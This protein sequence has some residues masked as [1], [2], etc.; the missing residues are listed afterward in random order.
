MHDM[1]VHYTNVR[2]WY[3]GPIPDTTIFVVSGGNK[4]YLKKKKKKRAMLEIIK[5]DCYL[6]AVKIEYVI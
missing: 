3:Q 5:R 6:R 2:W 1:T 4:V